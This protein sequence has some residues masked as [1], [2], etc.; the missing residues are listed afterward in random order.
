MEKD[1]LLKLGYKFYRIEKWCHNDKMYY[2][3]LVLKSLS[4]SWILVEKFDD[5][6]KRDRRFKEILNKSKY[7]LDDN[8][9]GSNMVRKLSDQGYLC[10]NRVVRWNGNTYLYGIEAYGGGAIT[11][12]LLWSA[13]RT[14]LLAKDA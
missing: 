4:G 7:N 9:D 14:N 1:D 2:T 3:I 10:V 5:A 6:S 11:G 8:G 13:L 12:I